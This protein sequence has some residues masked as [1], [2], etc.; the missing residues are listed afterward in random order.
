MRQAEVVKGDLGVLVWCDLETV[1]W[2]GDGEL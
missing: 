1:M 2:C